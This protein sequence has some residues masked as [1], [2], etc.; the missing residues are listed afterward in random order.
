MSGRVV[1]DDPEDHAAS[2][3][4]DLDETFTEALELTAAFT[5]EASPNLIRHLDPAWVEDAT[6]RARFAVDDF[7]ASA[8]FG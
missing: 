1:S 2:I 7:L 3:V 6:G 5:P 8:R 4:S